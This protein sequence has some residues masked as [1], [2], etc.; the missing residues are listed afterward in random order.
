MVGAFAVKRQ[1]YLKI[2]KFTGSY[3]DDVDILSY[4]LCIHFV[5]LRFDILV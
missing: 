4:N 2:N 3:I 5:S 1:I